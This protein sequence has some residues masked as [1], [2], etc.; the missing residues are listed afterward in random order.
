MAVGRKAQPPVLGERFSFYQEGF[1][2]TWSKAKLGTFFWGMMSK[3]LKGFLGFIGGMGLTYLH[4][5][6]GVFIG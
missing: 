3:F 2:G 6:L 4:L 1:L 5:G